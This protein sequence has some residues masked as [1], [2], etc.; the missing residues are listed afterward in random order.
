MC[1]WGLH[2]A[3]TF[4]ST[5]GRGACLLL[6]WQVQPP[7]WLLFAASGTDLS[8]ALMACR[9]QREYAGR[10]GG[11]TDGCAVFWY[12]LL[13][14]LKAVLSDGACCCTLFCSA[15][16]CSV[17]RGSRLLSLA[18]QYCWCLQPALF[19]SDVRSATHLLLAKATVTRMQLARRAM[20]LAFTYISSRILKRRAQTI[21][22][23]HFADRH[24]RWM[25]RTT[26]AAGGPT[27]SRCRT[28]RPSTLQSMA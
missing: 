17:A 18:V 24:S 3:S 21:A 11:R 23:R 28:A 16:L 22:A 25:S 13:Q 19:G 14:P 26:S 1:L 6:L 7:A 4:S 8:R 5:L 12:M 27:S 20:A 15:E 9:Y 10:T 2:R